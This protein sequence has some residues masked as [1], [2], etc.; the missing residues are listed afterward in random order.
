MLIR[1]KDTLRGMGKIL[2]LLV[3]I[4]SILFCINKKYI[5]NNS[6]KFWSLTSRHSKIQYQKKAY[7]TAVLLARTQH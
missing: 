4:D 5:Y 2:L 6:N 7:Y 1:K 3:C